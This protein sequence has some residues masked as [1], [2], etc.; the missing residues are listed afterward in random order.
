MSSGNHYE[1]NLQADEIISR[2]QQAYPKGADQ[3]QLAP[4]DQL[5]IGGI[6]ASQKLLEHL[7]D[8]EIVL[9][10]GSGLGGLMRLAQNQNNLQ[11]I[12][13]DISHG[14]N[15]LNCELA[16]LA[17]TEH[18][19]TVI[20]GDAHR[21][22][23]SENCFDSI[24]LQHSLLNMPD[25]IRVLDECLRVLQ[26]K[27]KLILH[28]VLEGENVTEMKFPVPWAETEFGSHLMQE[29]ELKALIIDAGFELESFAD[30]SAEA[31]KWRKRQASKEQTVKNLSPVVSPAMILGD[32]F[33]Q[34]A[35]NVMRNLANGTI[36]VIELVVS[37]K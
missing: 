28:E 25:P 16:G 30:W 10:I 37:K 36:R 17:N 12:G 4:I 23:F 3:Y 11:I 13:L 31:L 5:H 33:P 14:F 24:I 19:T 32:Q 27:G 21:L 34:M 1:Q 8:G 15:K 18:T 29:A 7:A 35:A 20:T 6:K 9:E 26:P 2:V 22:P